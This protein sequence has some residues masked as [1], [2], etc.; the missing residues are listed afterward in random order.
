VHEITTAPELA[1]SLVL[2]SA[3]GNHPPGSATSALISHSLSS[4]AQIPDKWNKSGNIT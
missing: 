3:V 4:A 1:P 2:H